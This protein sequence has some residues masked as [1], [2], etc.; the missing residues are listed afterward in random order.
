MSRL[1]AAVR[2]AAESRDMSWCYWDWATSFGAWNQSSGTWIEP[3]RS[4]LLDKSQ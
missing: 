3:M 2:T 4:A 1:S